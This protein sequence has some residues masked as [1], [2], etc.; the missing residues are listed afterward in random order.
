[1]AASARAIACSAWRGTSCQDKISLAVICSVVLFW[2]A[3][4]LGKGDALSS[5]VFLYDGH[6][7]GSDYYGPLYMMQ[8]GLDPWEG[9][10]N[11]PAGAYVFYRIAYHMIPPNS[12]A[13]WANALVGRTYSYAT[14]GLILTYILSI[15]PLW[16]VLR[17]MAGGSDRQKNLFAIAMLLCGPLFAA[18]VFG[19]I[20][21]VCLAPLFFYLKFY[22]SDKRWM[23]WVSYIALGVAASIKVYPAVFAMMIL[24]K[25]H[26]KEFIP[27][28]LMILA[29]FLLPFFWF[30]GFDSLLGFLRN[31]VSDAAWKADWGMGYVVSF[32]NLVKLIST[33]FG[34]YWEGEIP[35]WMKLIP[36]AVF[37]ALFF[38]SKEE[39]KKV[40]ACS[41]LCI[42][43]PTMS[44]TYMLALLIPPLCLLARRID[45]SRTLDS[46]VRFGTPL[47]VLLTATV[48]PYATPLIASVNERF[49]ELKL[50]VENMITVYPLSWGFVIVHCAVVLVVL[51]VLI[52][53]IVNLLSRPSKKNCSLKEKESILLEG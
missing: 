20:F 35:I 31:F 6:F 44:W 2:T 42:W 37:F 4:V 51:L 22:N 34:S 12:S 16:F 11:Y 3:L 40:F 5:Y 39:W 24:T 21:L 33:A 53:N 1:M 27:A 29:M 46:R 17:R 8:Y 30:Q 43:F 41:L 32:Q 10:I 7:W 49:Y 26:K 18:F 23:R 14:L 25:K 38:T 47:V 9:G 45:L 19:N 50:T 36:F 15:I 52:D 13:E 48:I 28:C